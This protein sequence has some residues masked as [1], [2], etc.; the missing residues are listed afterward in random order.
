[1]S[2][3]VSLIK[4]KPHDGFEST[5]EID[6]VEISHQLVVNCHTEKDR[7]DFLEYIEQLSG[8]AELGG[9]QLDEN[10]EIFEGEATK[11][12]LFLE[13]LTVELTKTIKHQDLPTDEIYSEDWLHLN[14]ISFHL[15]SAED[16]KA[17][18]FISTGDEEEIVKK[19]FIFIKKVEVDIKA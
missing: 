4:V 10:T 11:I 12:S 5:F 18:F 17:I 19:H 16:K 8:W 2:S 6:A 14:M 3:T 15:M 13:E 9:S 1:M 7:K